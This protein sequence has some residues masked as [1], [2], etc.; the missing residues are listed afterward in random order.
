M[1]QRVLKGTTPTLVGYPRLRPGALKESVVVTTAG[2]KVRTPSTPAPTSFTAV[3]VNIE[4]T[5]DVDVTA[6]A[7]AGGTALAVEGAVFVK[8]RR[9][10]MTVEGRSFEIESKSSGNTTLLLLGSPLPIDVPVG[11]NVAGFALT[12]AL[13]AGETSIV[14]EASIEWQATIDG[15]VAQWVD[16]FRVVAR[17]PKATLTPAQLLRLRPMM[18]SLAMPG[19]ATLED[20]I[21]GAWEGRMQVLL[22]R[23]GVFDEDVVSDEALVP[24][25]ALACVLHIVEDDPRFERAFVD[26][27]RKSFLTLTANTFGRAT[28]DEKGQDVEP[29]PRDPSNVEDRGRGVR[30]G[31]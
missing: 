23:N 14:G 3:T 6:P 8:D 4:S 18:R 17:I 29:T 5:V 26:D 30:V 11:A 13:T 22:E 24:L 21:A 1:E 25:H 27:M 2:A 9:Y 7:F 31:R 20:V 16:L 12:R 28:W 19:D 10:L 15:V